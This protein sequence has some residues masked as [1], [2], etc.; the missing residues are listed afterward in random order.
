MELTESGYRIL[1]VDDDPNLCE[2]LANF[3]GKHGINVHT[4]ADG[5]SMDQALRAHH[6]DL[7]ILDLMLPGEDGLSIAQRLKQVTTAP[8]IMLTALSDNIDR[9]VGLEIGADDYV[10][11]PFSPRILLA[12]I[13][14]VLRGHNSPYK[15][16]L[17]HIGKI[18]IVDSEAGV[19]ELLS[20]YLSKQGFE[21]STIPSRTELESQLGRTGFDLV[22]LDLKTPGEEALHLT[23]RLLR[24]RDIPFILLTAMSDE[25]EQ[26]VGLELGADDYIDKPLNQ[27]ELLARIKAVLRRT[28]GTSNA[29]YRDGIY[30]FGDFTFDVAQLSLTR[31]NG[32]IIPLTSVEYEMLNVFVKNPHRTLDR[33]RIQEL[34]GEDNKAEV[35]RNIDVRITRLRSKI[36]T[37][38]SNPMLIKTVWGRG[39]VFCPE[40]S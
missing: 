20:D 23:G 19:R 17:H 3:L 21:I 33:D 12:R 11:K 38:P 6:Y 25:V 37:N 39:Y 18:L 1:V 40:S 2:L 13:R 32:E 4:V 27:R 24:D 26:V 28:A 30:R 34:L 15:D 5:S 29:P 10:A 7:I 8:I 14:S 9:V 35:D 36:E 22:L 16:Q 31:E